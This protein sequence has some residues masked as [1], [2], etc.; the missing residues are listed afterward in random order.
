MASCQ[1]IFRFFKKGVDIRATQWYYVSVDKL[2]TKSKKGVNA[3]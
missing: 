2:P 3:L 1:H